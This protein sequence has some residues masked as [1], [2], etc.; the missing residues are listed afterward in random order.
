[1]KTYN[2][3]LLEINANDPSV[4]AINNAVTAGNRDGLGVWE[5]GVNIVQ[6]DVNYDAKRTPFLEITVSSYKSH[7]R[8]KTKVTNEKLKKILYSD[9]KPH[10]KPTAV[11]EL[12]RYL[13]DEG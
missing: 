2:E 1:M 10:L 9:V 11:A 5:D 12:D 8:G 6:A 4:K 7:Y 3:L 13:R